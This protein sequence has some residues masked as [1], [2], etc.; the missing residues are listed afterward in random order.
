MGFSTQAS[1][2]ALLKSIQALNR[3][4]AQH[5]IVGP[6]KSLLIGIDD[7]LVNFIM[8]IILTDRREPGVVPAAKTAADQLGDMAAN[9]LLHHKL[10]VSIQ[11]VV[12]HF[13][14]FIVKIEVGIHKLFQDIMVIDAAIVDVDQLGIVLQRAFEFFF[15]GIAGGIDGQAHTFIFQQVAQLLDIVILVLTLI[16]D[17]GCTE[18]GPERKRTYKGALSH[19]GLNNAQRVQFLQR[20]TYTQTANVSANSAS[21]GNLSPAFQIPSAMSC[22]GLV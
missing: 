9:K 16:K 14:D 10:N 19:S 12:A 15:F 5:F 7:A 6:P 20:H 21:E 13:H 3:D 17:R 8:R 4:N 18:R 11:F 2:F 22:L 1:F